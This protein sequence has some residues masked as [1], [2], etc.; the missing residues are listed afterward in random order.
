MKT[1]VAPEE[2]QEFDIRRVP[3]WAIGQIRVVMA[4][5]NATVTRFVNYDNGTG[6][7][8]V[9]I[10]EFGGIPEKYSGVMY[11]SEMNCKAP[12]SLYWEGW[13]E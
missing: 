1:S 11:K 3:I 8:Y 10:I 12:P 9:D 6:R 4:I 5:T 2:P 13:S 7:V